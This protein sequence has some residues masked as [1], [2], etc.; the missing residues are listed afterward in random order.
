MTETSWDFRGSAPKGTTVHNLTSV[1]IVPEGMLV[2]SST[3]G[4][5]ELPALTKKADAVTF[6][7]TNVTTPKAALIWR[8][9][10]LGDGEYYQAD[11]ELPR[12]QSHTVSLPLNDLDGWDWTAAS[13]GLAFPAGTELLVEK[14][15]WRGYSAVEK[16]RNAFLSFWTPDEFRLYSINFLWGPLL[17]TTPEARATLYDGLPPRSWSATRVFYALFALAAIGGGAYARKKENA[18]VIF[19][20]AVAAAGAAL[21]IAFDVR[22]T[23]EILSYVRDDWKT[24]VLAPE[25]KRT[26]RSHSNLYDVLHDTAE[27]LADDDRYVLLVNDDTPFFANARYAMYP[28]VPVAPERA[29]GAI[30]WIVLGNPRVSV[31]SGALLR[32]GVVLSPKGAVI[33]RFDDTTFLYR[34]RP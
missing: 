4:F 11:V 24:Y 5:V 14:M 16:T 8:T 27:L 17:A 15:E 33:K 12:G 34:S 1:E 25:N 10:E 6:T 31:H 32:D 30:A 19:L 18:R 7:V 22:M 21:W 29:S 20:C 26:L 2:R 13:I 9:P 3:D 23:Q 28:A